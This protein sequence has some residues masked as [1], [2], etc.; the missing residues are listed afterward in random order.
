M[1]QFRAVLQEMKTTAIENPGVEIYCLNLIYFMFFLRGIEFERTIST[2]SK[3]AITVYYFIYI[4][5]TFSFQQDASFHKRLLSAIGFLVDYFHA[6]G[7]GV[8]KNT[9]L[10][11]KVYKVKRDCRSSYALFDLQLF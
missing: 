5:A 3:I 1:A 2:R 8:P 10:E 6:S 4:T 7:Q 9:I 11:D